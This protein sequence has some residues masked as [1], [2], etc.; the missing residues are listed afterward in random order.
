MKSF[1][2]IL[3]FLGI[4]LWLSAQ[5]STQN[6]IVT[7]VPTVPVTNPTTLTD[8]NSGS[9]S[10]TTIQYFDGLGR[11]METVQKAQSSK[12]ESTWVDLVGLTEYDVVGRDYKHWLMAPVTGNTGAYV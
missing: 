1:Y 5:T 4:P 2:Y 3:L 7:T 8:V 11:P 6:Y 10:N 9:N 12:D